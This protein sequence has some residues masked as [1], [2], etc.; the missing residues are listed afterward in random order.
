MVDKN[1]SLDA[2]VGLYGSTSRSKSTSKL[3]G[4][5]GYQLSFDERLRISLA[6]I[7]DILAIKNMGKL[8]DRLID[9]CEYHVTESNED[10][11]VNVGGKNCSS[12]NLALVNSL[13]QSGLS[14]ILLS[15]ALFDARIRVI[16]NLFDK[17]TIRMFAANDKNKDGEVAK[18]VVSFYTSL[19]IASAYLTSIGKSLVLDMHRIVANALD[20]VNESP[21]IDGM[22]SDAHD[23]KVIESALTRLVGSEEIHTSEPAKFSIDEPIERLVF[24]TK[25]SV[26]VGSVDGDSDIIAEIMSVDD[27]ADDELAPR[28]IKKDMSITRKLMRQS[29]YQLSDSEKVFVSMMPVSDIANLARLGNL[30]RVLSGNYI[31]LASKFSSPSCIIDKGERVNTVAYLRKENDFL[32]KELKKVMSG[33][34]SFNVKVSQILLRF[35]R[36]AL[37]DFAVY[38]CTSDQNKARQV[39]RFFALLEVAEA[40]LDVLMHEVKVLS[41]EYI[42]NICNDTSLE[43]GA[44]VLLG[45]GNTK[46]DSLRSVAH[47]VGVTYDA[48]G[49]FIEECEMK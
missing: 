44:E 46:L 43:D 33:G 17:K 7:E 35:D 49:D 31:K 11:A 39:V 26:P 20:K 10:S 27:D 41:N 24:K 4:L 6:P 14:A 19:N 25:K 42:A 28:V 15:D 8:G 38:D 3:I 22:L 40:Y 37:L 9:Y 18:Q 48:F 21:G 47:L 1:E 2:T 23:L 12:H 45:S 16:F 36:N 13:I 5:I 34:V 29:G 30:G 32:E